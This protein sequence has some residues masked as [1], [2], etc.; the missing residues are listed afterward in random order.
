MTR[1]YVQ[2]QEV[3]KAEFE[4]AA[5]ANRKLFAAG[6]GSFEELYECIPILAIK[7]DIK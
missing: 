5:E 4:I 7:E 6:D 1:Y 3:S 2:G